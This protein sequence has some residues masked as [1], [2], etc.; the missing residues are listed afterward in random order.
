MGTGVHPIPIHAVCSKEDM[1]VMLSQIVVEEK[2]SFRF[3]FK[4]HWVDQLY[5]IIA[6]HFW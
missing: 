6:S 4:E 3:E 1:L 2:K 5:D